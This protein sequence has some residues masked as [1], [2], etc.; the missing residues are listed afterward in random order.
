MMHPP[1]PFKFT[2]GGEFNYNNVNINQT[3]SFYGR[4]T[5]FKFYNKE[6]N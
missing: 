2:L 1:D 5:K 4:L 6:L 3:V